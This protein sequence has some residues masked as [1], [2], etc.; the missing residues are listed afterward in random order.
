[1]SG[2]PDVQSRLLCFP[3]GEKVQVQLDF[4]HGVDEK[5]LVGAGVAEGTDVLTNEHATT[6]HGLEVPVHMP[7]PHSAA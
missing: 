2:A 6:V 3:D 1:M 7:E 5:L 4:C